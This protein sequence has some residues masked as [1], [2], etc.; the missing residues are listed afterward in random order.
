[1]ISCNRV[2]HV[3][4]NTCILDWLSFRRISGHPLK[5]RWML[6]VGRARIPW[7]N[8]SRRRLQ[9][10]PVWWAEFNLLVYVSEHCW[11]Y[12]F[13]FNTLDLFASRPDITQIHFFAIFT[14]ADRLTLKI[15]VNGSSWNEI[16]VESA[17]VVKDGAT[18]SALWFF[19]PR[20]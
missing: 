10:L 7:E 14:L 4:Q 8:L 13:A 9:F 12:I 19:L 2:P 5:E 11:D 6:D 1:M 16:V 17:D 15:N 3:E 20:A 18:T